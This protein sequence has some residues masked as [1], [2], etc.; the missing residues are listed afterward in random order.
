MREFQ[1]AIPGRLRAVS[2]GSKML[3]TA[4]A[5][6]AVVGLLVSWRLYGAAVGDAGP[7][8]YYAGAEVA[9]APAKIDPRP[10]SG[11][12]IDLAPEAER[13]RVMVVQMSER[14]LLEVTHFHLF[15]IP[16]Y[17]LVLAH[18]WLLAKLPLRL[19]HAGVVAAVLTSG[20]HI[21]APWLVRGSAGLAVLMPISGVAMLLTLGGMAVVTTIDMWLPQ[22]PAPPEPPASVGVNPASALAE[23]RRRRAEAAEKA[24][25]PSAA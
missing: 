25:P 9:A 11:P 18:L 15:T 21:A 14:K 19:Q 24:P 2:L 7:A 22:P 3:Y 10:A 5:I 6:A 8:A 23:L 4:F 17:V 1:A 20:L 16:I 13:P 12:A